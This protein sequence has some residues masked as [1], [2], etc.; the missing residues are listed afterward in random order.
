MAALFLTLTGCQTTNQQ[1]FDQTLWK[2]SATIGGDD[3]PRQT[4]LQSL[5]SDKVKIGHSM[6]DVQKLLGSPY[7]ALRQS[8]YYR[9][10]TYPAGRQSLDV[11]FGK[12]K[13]VTKVWING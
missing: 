8:G 4:M 13:R 9:V 10:W 11:G 3:N 1:P 12:D 7:R 2:T 5:I 6:A